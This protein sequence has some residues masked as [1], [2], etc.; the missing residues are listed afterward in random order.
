MRRL[1]VLLLLL[2]PRLAPAQDAERLEP[3]G[4]VPDGAVNDASPSGVEDTSSPTDASAT[5][6]PSGSG[7]NKP[8]SE[9]PQQDGGVRSPAADRAVAGQPAAAPPDV[10]AP[11]AA[12]A[13]APAATPGDGPPPGAPPPATAPS[14]VAPPPAAPPPAAV[15]PGSAPLY[16]TRVM[17]RR[18]LSKDKTQ[19]TTRIDGQRLR[20]SA[21]GTTFEAVSQEAADVYVPARGVGLHGVASGATGGVRIRGLG[22]SPNCQILVVEDG[23][24][25]YQGIFGHPIPDAYVPFLIDEVLVVKGGDSVLYGTNAMAGALIIRSRWQE[26]EGYELQADTAFGSYAT[27]RESASLLGRSGGWDLAAAITDLKTDGHRPSAGGNDLVGTTALR[28]RLAPSLKLAVRNKV[29]HVEGGDPGPVTHPTID[30]GFDVWRAGASVHL[31]YSREAFRL[32]LTPYLNMGVHRLYDGFYSHDYVSGGTGE[33]DLRLHRTM[34]LL[35]GMAAERVAGDVVNRVTGERPHVQAFLDVSL[36]NQITLRPTDSLTL[37]LGSRE[38]WSSKYGRVFL[39]K[40]GARQDIAHGFFVHAR[41]ARNFR[42]PTIRELYLPYPTANPDLKPEYALN[43]DVGAGYSS[44]HFEASCTGYRTD[45]RN[46]IKYFGVWPA[47]E[48]VNIDHIVIWG[49]EGRIGVRGL[50][51][52]SA[53]ASGDWQDVGRYTRQNPDAKVDLTVEATHEWNDQLA[54]GS[55]TGEWVHGLFMADY[56]RQPLPDVFVMDLALRYRYSSAERGLSVEPYLLLRNFLDRRYAYVEDYPMPGFN[57]LAG[58]R[59]VI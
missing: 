51:P 53:F 52:F 34:T 8:G 29:V 54:S 2:T 14:A 6:D 7:A 38:L 11:A 20:D 21:R 41:V 1:A 23:V 15:S 44:E 10:A 43:A 26:Q 16:E 24:P 39:Y 25:D 50:G 30:H 40:A 48:V 45:A 35:L 37:V 3:D 42:Q 19:D 5:R 46:L 32:T 28:Y 47:A 22:G 55:L 58:L 27:V 57:V 13:A 18:P 12:A 33:L 17:V 56:G 49:V 59:I 9:L 4:T 31:A 36:Y